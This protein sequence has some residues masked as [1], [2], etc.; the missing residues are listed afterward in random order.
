MST[1]PKDIPTLSFE[2]RERQK[3]IYGRFNTAVALMPALRDK[4]DFTGIHQPGD[5]N[6]Y[7]KWADMAYLAASAVHRKLEKEV[8]EER[9]LTEGQFKQIEERQ[10]KEKAA[11]PPLVPA[12]ISPLLV[13]GEVKT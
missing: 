8:E 11:N 13:D 7:D 10:A 6:D 3:A 5:P 9:L 1:I 12:A 4:F 2:Q